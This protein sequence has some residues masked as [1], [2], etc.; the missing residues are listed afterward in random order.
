MED[1]DE[2]P[3]INIHVDCGHVTAEPIRCQLCEELMCPLC[4]KEH[5]CEQ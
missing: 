1:L 5:D 3:G 2:A 4:M